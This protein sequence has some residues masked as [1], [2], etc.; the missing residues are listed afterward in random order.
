LRITVTNIGPVKRAD[1]DLKPLLVFVGPNSSGKSL[2]AETIYAVFSQMGIYGSLPPDDPEFMRFV[3][4]AAAAE[5]AIPE[6][7]I[8]AIAAEYFK[9]V[10]YDAI[11]FVLE[12]IPRELPRVTGTPLREL[13]RRPGNGASEIVIQLASRKPAW[14]ADL[15]P[16]SGR[17][18]VGQVP[19]PR[20]A[21]EAISPRDWEVLSSLN[22]SRLLSYFD[23]ALTAAC[24]SEAPRRARFLPAA[25]AGILQWY[26]PLASSL[27][28]RSSLAGMA[29]GASAP[30]VSGVLA[31]FIGMLI[32][33]NPD[34]AG[35]FA[36][37][38][39]RL[40]NEVIHGKIVLRAASGLTP[41]I[42]YRDRSGDYSIARSPSMA[43]ELA[44][45]VLYLRYR[46]R[47]NDLLVIEE[48]EAHL[49]PAAQAAFARS[50]VRL[51]NQGLR[52]CLTTHS[53][54]FL[55]QISNAIIAGSVPAGQRR[56]AEALEA[57]Q[58]GAYFFAPS[59]AGTTVSELPIDPKE[60]IAEETF[61]A[62]S[63]QL[64]NEAVYLDRSRGAQTE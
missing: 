58:V 38:A 2:I 23:R 52:I 27:I 26:R 35:S 17:A 16:E 5:G 56:G 63:E 60:G 59:E 18:E 64:Y 31:D 55:Q 30:E 20:A 61:S 43:S 32:E 22:S 12:E 13:R 6:G 24:F 57:T 34:R 51:V 50:L 8:P 19:D 47:P 15:W 49:H 37:E 4:A 48:P 14:R 36:Y 45:V 40:E 11:R 1:I 33:L 42:V 10:L 28:R 25:R 54:F 3:T 53:E 62:V 7:D 9:D 29:E 21:L 41:D 39:D 46:L 44:P